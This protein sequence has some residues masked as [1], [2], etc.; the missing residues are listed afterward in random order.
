VFLRD[1]CFR[2]SDIVSFFFF[3]TVRFA[4]FSTCNYCC[5]N[6]FCLPS[7]LL[8]TVRVPRARRSVGKKFS[9]IWTRPLLGSGPRHSFWLSKSRSIAYRSDRIVAPEDI[10]YALRVLVHVCTY[11][12]AYIHTYIHTHICIFLYIDIYSAILFWSWYKGNEN[13]FLFFSLFFFGR[14]AVSKNG[15][16][17]PV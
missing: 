15:K 17:S 3:Q 11:I 16:K 1:F 9:Q 7:P 14:T 5:P 13:H 2:C 12:W 6:Y 4:C 10:S 8:L